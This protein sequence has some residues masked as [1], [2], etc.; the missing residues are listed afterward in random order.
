MLDLSRLRVSLAVLTVLGLTQCTLEGVAPDAYDEDG[1]E[2]FFIE[3]PSSEPGS[4]EGLRRCAT[5]PP[6]TAQQQKIRDQLAAVTAMRGPMLPSL[7]GSIDIPVAFHVLQTTGGVGFVS[8]ADIDAQIAV[9]NDSYSGATSGSSIDTPFRFV[10]SSVD[11]TTNNSWARM[12]PGSSAEANAKSSLRVGG[13]DT[14]NLYTADIGGG[15]L[16]WATF[17]DSYAGNPSD[18]GVVVL[19]SSLPGGSAAPFNE[20]DTATHEVGHWLGLY[21]TFQG[22]CGGAGDQVSDT[23]AEASPAYG[24]PAGRDTCGGGGVDPI[25]NFMDY[26]DDACMD[27]LTPGQSTRMD[28]LFDLYRN[29]ASEICDDG[30]DNDGDGDIDCA[31][32]ECSASPGC[33]TEY[34]VIDTIGGLADSS[35]ASQGFQYDTN[36]A[37]AMKFE[38]SGGS[39]DADLYVRFGAAPTTSTYDCRPYLNGNNETCEFDPAQS[40][41]YYVMVR[42]YTTYSG[43]TL[44]VSAAGAT[45]PT[46]E[47]CDDGLDNDGDG[48][49]DC[50]DADCAAD[51]ACAVPTPEVCDDG[52]DNDG[53]G[54]IDCVDTDCAADP[55]CAVACP[56]GEHV[57]TLSSSNRNDYYEYVVA[58][59]GLYEASLSGPGGANYDLYLQYWNGNRWRNRR[60]STGP[61]ANELISYNEASVVLHRWRVRRRSG[62]GDYTLCITSP[63]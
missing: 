43:A 58:L 32:S 14:L 53:D 8:Q 63:E 26:T 3:P 28:D 45:P 29:V 27:E 51:P 11:Y 30:L 41:T 56:G 50:V 54:D 15:L 12:S 48:D 6:T 37:T 1:D 34:T 25:Y 44:T 59:D 36:G 47:V 4:D 46:P 19:Y 57:G 23:P 31:D 52:L 61:D 22:G 55:V 5:P 17:P 38:L 42:A 49:I 40:G 60:R 10:L 18:D 39:G 24:C 2:T 16:G 62:S 13:P 20:G 21:H 9:L 33:A 7:P 35:G